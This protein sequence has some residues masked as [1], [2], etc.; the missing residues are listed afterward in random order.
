V[1]TC[2]LT[3]RLAGRGNGTG[4]AG[5]TAYFFYCRYLDYLID[6]CPTFAAYWTHEMV[7][8]EPYEMNPR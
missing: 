5:R 2:K 6:L 3:D 4:Q 8:D 7:S 1:R